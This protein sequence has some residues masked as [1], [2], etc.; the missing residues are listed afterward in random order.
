MPFKKAQKLCFLLCLLIVGLLGC[1]AI[2]SISHNGTPITTAGT[3][4]SVSTPPLHVWLQAEPGVEIR[5]EHWRSPGPDEDTVIITRFD[6]HRIHLAVKYQPSQPLALSDW[7]AREHA[8]A[9][10]NGGYFDER[11]KATGLVVSEGQAYGTSYD[12]FGGMLSVDTQGNVRLRS[13]HQQPYDPNNEQ[14]QQ[15]T[16]S[17]P[18]LAVNGQRTQFNANAASQRR[19]VVAMDKQGRLLLIVSPIEAFTLDE[20]ADLLASSDLSIDTALNLDGGSST[21]LYVNAGNRHVTINSL[22][23]LPIVIVLK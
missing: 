13:L 12:G 22:A 5:Y 1:D 23:A 20:L 15:V 11:N 6:L 18:M 4:T 9:I 21:G 10:I 2:P 14:L 16:Q 7:M 8:I 19:S 3:A 17:A